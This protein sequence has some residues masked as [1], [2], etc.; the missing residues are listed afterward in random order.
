V[1]FRDTDGHLRPARRGVDGLR[2][3]PGRQPRRTLGAPPPQLPPAS[4]LIMQ[5]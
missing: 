5:L 3:R 1:I 2:P 4:A